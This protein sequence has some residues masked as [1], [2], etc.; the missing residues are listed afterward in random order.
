[1]KSPDN[2]KQVKQWV[3]NSFSIIKNKNLGEQNFSIIGRNPNTR[4]HI[5]SMPYEGNEHEIIAFNATQDIH[6]VTI[7]FAIKNDFK[8]F[9]RRSMNLLSVLVAHKGPG[10][11]YQCLKGQNYIS[12]ITCDQ[13]GCCV[14]A[15]RFVT[16][17]IAMTEVGLENYK[18][19][20]AIIFRYFEI[21]HD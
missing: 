8:L 19:V 12:R 9:Y 14:T 1:M 5:G 20:L 15:M 6:K 16:M 2:L 18:K 7:A 10:S 13:N 21:V 4:E 3:V 11:L 17:E